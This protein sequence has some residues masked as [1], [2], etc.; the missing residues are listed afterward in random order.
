M[1]VILRF[2]KILG[3]NCYAFVS[4]NLSIYKYNHDRYFLFVKN[5]NKDEIKIDKG[6]TMYAQA[7]K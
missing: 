2:S 7:N 3:A 1:P 5:I 6:I 4:N